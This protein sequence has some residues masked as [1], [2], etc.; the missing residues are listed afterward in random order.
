MRRILP[1][2]AIVA[3]LGCG[4]DDPTVPTEPLNASFDDV[5]A[6]EALWRSHH[7]TSYEVQQAVVCFCAGPHAW[8][9]VVRDGRV[10]SRGYTVEAI[11]DKIRLARDGADAY[12]A[13]FDPTYGYPVHFDVDWRFGAADDE[14]SI[15]MSDLRP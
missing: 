11:F 8:T 12:R 6:A 2:L 9:A 7:I 10:Q 1:V 15:D 13:S 5:D 4:P 3:A 14:W